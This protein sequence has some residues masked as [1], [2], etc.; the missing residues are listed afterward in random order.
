VTISSSDASKVLLSTNP[1]T[2]G[3]NS[4][5]LSVAAG[6]T[7]LQFYVQGVG[8]PA[9]SQVTLTASASGYSGSTATMVVTGSAFLV[10]GTGPNGM[11]VNF[12]T[13]IISASTP[14]TVAIWQLD[15]S[16]RPLGS[17]AGQLRPGI[18]N[19]AVAVTS[20]TPST[21][22][23]IGSPAVFNAGDSLNTSLSFQPQNCSTTP[24]T[25]VLSVTQPSGFSVPASGGQLTVT[26]DKP[27]VTL[28]MTV[29]TIGANLEV[30]GSGALDVPA[31]SD[32]PVTI[33]SGDKTKVLLS[34]SP[35][36]TGSQSITVTVPAGK[37][38]NAFG[39]PS[40][41]VYALTKSGTVTLTAS[42]PAPFKSSTFSVTLAP[43]GFVIDGG[44][45]VG[46]DVGTMLGRDVTLTVS[47]YV[48]DPSSL[49]PLIPEA[50]SGGLAASP[51]VAVTSD[52]PAGVVSGSPVVIASGNA[53]GTATLHAASS[54][55][56][57]VTAATPS[58]PKGFTTPSSGTSLKV[59]IQ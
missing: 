48:L 56:A 27:A 41:Y 33:T 4:I 8:G 51:S 34:T 39:F 13:T 37:G 40:Y 1:T 3:T 19:L 44:N 50:L 35:T 26:V 7:L 12:A 59:V 38:V 36:G 25:T 43:A 22:T 58:T 16:L 10:S 23:V 57:T 9:G 53:S 28:R 5:T 11:G 2:L 52:N 31:P 45:G 6:T 17:G 20:G 21:G 46:I 18:S 32:L 49:A 15:S 14:L 30:E 47:A 54:G 29:T 24:C 55:T 42:A